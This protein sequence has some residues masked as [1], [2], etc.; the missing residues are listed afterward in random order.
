M[1][2]ISGGDDVDKEGSTYHDYFV[3]ADS[4]TVT[5]FGGTQ[6]RGFSG[7]SGELEVDLTAELD[8]KLLGNF[9]CVLN[10]TTLEHIFEVRVAFRNLCHLSKDAVILIVPFC[11]VQHENAGYA[12]YWRFTPTC[13]R[14]LFSDEGFEIIYEA[15]N[16]R[17]NESVYI[18]MVAS[19]NPADWRRRMPTFRPL[20]EVGRNFGKRPSFIEWLGMLREII[21]R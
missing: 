12:D 3:A 17:F 7:R 2:N 1:A 18:L 4:Y 13:L 21:L 20:A 9:D 15:A 19:R 14:K 10:H 8:A 11:Q 16:S 5:N 6:Y